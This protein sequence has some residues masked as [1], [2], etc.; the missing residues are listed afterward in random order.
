MMPAIPRKPLGTSRSL[1]RSKPYEKPA[2][3]QRYSSFVHSDD[4]NGDAFSQTPILDTADKPVFPTYVQY[5]RIEAAYLE[6][7]SPQK[8][9]KALISQSMF[10]NIWDVLHQSDAPLFTLQF[11]F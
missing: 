11:R 3:V 1:S 6:S 9:G 2:F 7:L 4:G 8:R 10:D 5:K